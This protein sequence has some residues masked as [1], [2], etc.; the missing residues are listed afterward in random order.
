MVTL[1]G[2]VDTAEQKAEAGRIASETDGVRSVKNQLKV[3]ART[4]SV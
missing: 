4:K 2:T 3:A 1:R